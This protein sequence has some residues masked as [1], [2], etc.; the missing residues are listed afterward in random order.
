M[1]LPTHIVASA[2]A[3]TVQG[4]VKEESDKDSL[5][6]PIPAGW[7]LASGDIVNIKQ[8]LQDPKSKAELVF[9]KKIVQEAVIPPAAAAPAAVAIGAAGVSQNPAADIAKSN[10][11]K[12][13]LDNKK[14]NEQVKKPQKSINLQEVRIHRIP[15]IRG[16]QQT[17]CYP[18]TLTL[19]DKEGLP[20]YLHPLS[21]FEDSDIMN[22]TD[23]PDLLPC[24]NT[25]WTRYYSE[26]DNQ[27]FA[28]GWSFWIGLLRPYMK[29]VYFH[30]LVETGCFTQ[31]EADYFSKF[32]DAK[33]LSK[34]ENDIRQEIM[35]IINAGTSTRYDECITLA[36]KLHVDAIAESKK[37]QRL[38]GRKYK[39]N[40]PHSESYTDF[41]LDDQEMLYLLGLAFEKISPHHALQA[42]SALTQNSLLYDAAQDRLAN[43]Y[44][45]L[46]KKDADADSKTFRDTPERRALRAKGLLS[47]EDLLQAE[48]I[49]LFYSYLDLQCGFHPLTNNRLFGDLN[50]IFGEESRLWQPNERLSN[51]LEPL[52]RMVDYIHENN[53]INLKEQN[54]KL[55]D[56]Q[57]KHKQENLGLS[58]SSGG[59]S[60]G[61][62]SAAV[63]YASA[64]NTIGT[65]TRSDSRQSNIASSN[66]G[67]VKTSW[68]IQ[69]DEEPSDNMKRSKDELEALL[70]A[71]WT[72]A[73]GNLTALLENE[74]SQEIITFKRKD[75]ALENQVAIHQNQEKPIK[76][77]EIRM[78]RTKN[79]GDGYSISLA[80][81]THA[82]GRFTGLALGKYD[83]P[84]SLIE[85]I[86]SI[87]YANQNEVYAYSIY[88]INGLQM[89][90]ELVPKYLTDIW[91][92]ELIKK[93][94]WTEQEAE[95]F[96]SLCP[97]LKKTSEEIKL[98]KEI[99]AY[100][101]KKDY[102]QA[103][104]KAQ[105]LHTLG[106]KNNHELVWREYLDSESMYLA[107][108]DCGYWLGL[109]LLTISPYHAYKSFALITHNSPRYPE[110]QQYML[111]LAKKLA[112]IAG[113]KKEQREYLKEAV[114]H[115]L[116]TY[117]MNEISQ[118]EFNQL[119][120]ELSGLTDMEYHLLSKST[121]EFDNLYSDSAHHD[122]ILTWKF[123]ILTM[124][125]LSEKIYELNARRNNTNVIALNAGAKPILI[126]LEAIAAVGSMSPPTATAA[127]AVAMA[128]V[129][130][131]ATSAAVL[132][133]TTSPPSSGYTL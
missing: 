5:D 24:A 71:G 51:M 8:L 18:I 10:Q 106:L 32:I 49:K 118:P 82:W 131:A 67:T 23:N 52:F 92:M 34:E 120:S 11:D 125:G 113:D 100:L 20:Y 101:D 81:F 133:A 94:V 66:E 53:E 107:M 98:R 61:A 108:E 75:V 112:A 28:K 80:L 60:S 43:L 88:H 76:A 103:I 14:A 39:D 42:F 35:D 68:I 59:S 79:R 40:D 12:E 46:L 55:I 45:I 54:A 109:C 64:A 90:M 104:A 26:L 15:E 95:F 93:G 31:V 65:V 4:L 115:C 119:I 1:A 132:A 63:S 6:S 2:T 41:F 126:S 116:Y 122:V 77:F 127:P 70:P 33:T 25:K 128:P 130:A 89:R 111:V 73:S 19:I 50:S 102:D 110:A 117:A 74:N 13:L 27:T 121:P 124:L 9:R 7:E 114:K 96:M 86:F 3:S 22:E 29:T 17:G 62:G 99:K 69:E 44:F 38:N 83:F 84:A 85:A 72:W 97:K 56:S 30:L 87:K 78:M 21:L 129:V 91:K 37:F 57:V 123:L 16:N 36:K 48:N 47:M 105:A 58:V